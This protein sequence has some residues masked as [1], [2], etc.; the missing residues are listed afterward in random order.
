MEDY[1]VKTEAM[2]FVAMHKPKLSA[3]ESHN[4]VEML[5]DFATEQFKLKN[6]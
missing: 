4:L 1:N 6:L 5:S 3:A 2:K